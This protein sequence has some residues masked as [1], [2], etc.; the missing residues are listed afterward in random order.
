MPFLIKN[1]FLKLE[2]QKKKG[3]WASPKK[4][5]TS[6]KRAKLLKYLLTC[7]LSKS[8]Y[9]KIISC[10]SAK[11]ISD[12]LQ[13]LYEGIDQVKE[14]KITMLVHQYEI[15]KMLDHEILMI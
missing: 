7:A 2:K 8:E 14:T 1:I 3:K 5:R 6:L 13:T 9:D 15:F 11:E 12:R 4:A 10:D